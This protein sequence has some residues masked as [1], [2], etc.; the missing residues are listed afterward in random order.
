MKEGA[1]QPQRVATHSGRTARAS[2][3]AR[4]A[5]SLPP[6]RTLLR[7]ARRGRGG[8][9]TRPAPASVRGCGPDSAATR[10]GLQQHR[11]QRRAASTPPTKNS[12]RQPYA[13]QNLRA[14]HA[15]QRAAERDA[16]DRHRDR[17]G[18][19]A[20]RNVLGGE[21]RRVR[22]RAA[23]ARAGDE[24][25]HAERHAP[26]S[27]KAIATV[28]SP[29]RRRRCR[30]APCGG[31]SDRRV[32]R[33]CAADHHPDRPRRRHRG[34]CRSRQRP[35]R[36]S[37]PAWPCGSSWLS[38]PSRMTVQRGAG[39]EQLLIAGPS[40]FV[41]HGRDVDGVRHLIGQLY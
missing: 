13:G 20:P 22:H 32:C 12:A 18:T 31:R 28:S 1:A 17:E 14:R 24:S 41:E 10:A 5:F 7:P 25:Q 4:P 37:T 16:D 3:P 19:M 35:F 23:E 30:A 29:E 26:P 15:R 21:R 33:R 36:A 2:T 38:R 8:A 40:S 27:T 9:A 34:E 39:D 11:R 6:R